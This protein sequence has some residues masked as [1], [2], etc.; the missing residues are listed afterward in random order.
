MLRGDFMSDIDI[1]MHVEFDGDSY[2][3]KMSS[4]DNR[5][6]QLHSLGQYGKKLKIGGR[7]EV[8]KRYIQEFKKLL[9]KEVM[10]IAINLTYELILA[11]GGTTGN[12]A[13]AWTVTVSRADLGYKGYFDGDPED[14]FEVWQANIIAHTNTV[15]DGRVSA[16]RRLNDARDDLKASMRSNYTVHISNC[17]FVDSATVESFRGR[18]KKIGGE[19]YAT[20]VI[21]DGAGMVKTSIDDP[22]QYCLTIFHTEFANAIRRVRYALQDKRKR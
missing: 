12:T 15:Q 4:L 5:L 20:K 1:R 19:N 11:T 3:K 18:T 21:R 17:A 2:I 7:K 13:S 16:I 14:Y 6:Q 10:D 9:A 22:E 8:S